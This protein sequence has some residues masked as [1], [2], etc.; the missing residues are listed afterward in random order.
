MFRYCP[1]CASQD[2][3]FR[4]NKFRC[5]GC[6][7]TYYHNTAAA[8]ACIVRAGEA[9]LFLVRGKEP[10]GGKLDLPGGFVDPGEG[11]MEGLRREFREEIGWEP[12]AAAAFTLFASFPNIY[13]YKGIVY[14]TCD[15]FFTLSAPDLKAED[16]RLAAGE[17]AGVRFIRPADI[18]FEDL[19]FDSTRR[20]VR[21]FLDNSPSAT[22]SQY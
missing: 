11:A 12:P 3:E 20:A 19:A 6:G 13:P 2:I 10:A 5:P 9:L 22:G 16:L 1:S 21:A 18:P 4:G 7:F 14:N 17:I 15:L 8:T